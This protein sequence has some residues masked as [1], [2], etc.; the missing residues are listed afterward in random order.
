[1]PVKSQSPKQPKP[2]A[3]LN[4]AATTSAADS[5]P[6]SALAGGAG[7]SLAR[8]VKLLGSLLGQV[9][10]EQGGQQLLEL[11]ERSRLRSIAFR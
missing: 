10:A 2:R 8:E 3:A 7:D 1:M 6:R 11:V 5:E 9:I 4:G